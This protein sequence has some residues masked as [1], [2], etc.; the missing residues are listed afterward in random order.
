MTPSWY[1]REDFFRRIPWGRTCGW[2]W[3]PIKAC[4]PVGVEKFENL[5]GED[6]RPRRV[7]MGIAGQLREVVSGRCLDED[8]F[9]PPGKDM[10][11]LVGLA[12]AAYGEGGLKPAHACDKIWLGCFQ[13]DVVR[14]SM[15]A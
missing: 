10:T 13:D 15:M 8:A 12:I 14:L 7:E 6:V 3:E 11:T 9:I 5:A 1:A 4:P 2:F